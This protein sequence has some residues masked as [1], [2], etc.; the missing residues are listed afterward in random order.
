MYRKLVTIPVA[1]GL[2]FLSHAHAGDEEPRPAA[3]FRSL[4]LEEAIRTALAHHPS[5][6][7]AREEIAAAEART[8]QVRSNYY[9]Q[10]STSGF[11][12]QGLSGAAGALGLRGLV[13]SPLFRDI[14]SSA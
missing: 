6:R 5:L 14:G 1:A 12:K 13:T 4:T 3:A 8:G 2:L 9:P 10:V 11:A 7:R